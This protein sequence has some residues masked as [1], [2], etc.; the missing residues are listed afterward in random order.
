MDRFGK[1]WRVVRLSN[2][3]HT[4]FMSVT[5]WR[6][7]SSCIEVICVCFSKVNSK[8]CLLCC[9]QLNKQCMYFS[10]VQVLFVVCCMKILID[11]GCTVKLSCS[12]KSTCCLPSYSSLSQAETARHCL[13]LRLYRHNCSFCSNQRLT[14]VMFP[15]FFT[16]SACGRDY[17]YKFIR[18]GRSLFCCIHQ[19]GSCNTW[20]EAT[21]VPAH[22]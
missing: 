20:A 14:A 5:Y 15:L 10:C 16:L 3:L 12:H 9:S 17:S 7:L 2:Q 19:D 1:F 22:C 13:Q 4:G 8:L 11:Y 21:S 18:K 6:L